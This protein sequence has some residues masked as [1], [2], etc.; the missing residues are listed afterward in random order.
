MRERH[1]SEDPGAER[2]II[3]RYIFRKWDVGHGLHRSDSG[4]GPVAGT[5]ECDNE[6]SVSIKCGEFLD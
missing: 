4:E 3:L 1:H 2:R 6:L 5:C